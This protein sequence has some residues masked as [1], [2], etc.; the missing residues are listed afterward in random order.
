MSAKRAV[1]SGLEFLN[2]GGPMGE[3]IRRHDWSA[4]ALGAIESWP[5]HLKTATAV[6]L[7]SKVPIVMLWGETGVMIYNDGYSVFAGAR[8]PQLLGSDVREGWPEVADFNDHVMKTGLAGG[9]LSY[10]DQELTLNRHGRAEQVWM[11]LDYSPLLDEG[12]EPAGVMAIVVETTSKVQAERR[13]GGE[14]QR[15]AQLFEQAPSF[16]AMVH[17]PSFRFEMANPSYV[18]LIGHRDLIGRTVAEVLPEVARQGYLELL[19]KVYRSGEVYLAQAAPYAMQVEPGGAVTQRY[20]DFVYQPIRDDSG[21]VTDIFVEGTDVTSRVEDERR[22][23]AL[24]RLTELLREPQDPDGVAFVAARLLGQTLAVSRVGYGTIDLGAETLHIKR[25]WHAPGV[26]TLSGTTRLRDY[27][28]FID[29]LKNNEFISIADVRDDPRTATA[30]GAL[31]GRSA[32]AFVNVPVLEQGLLVAVMFINHWQRRDWSTAELDFVREVAN[33]TRMAVERVKG[34][35]ARAAAARAEEAAVLA[36]HA[37]DRQFRALVTASSDVIY[38]M[39]PAWQQ[40]RSLY[41]GDFLESATPERASWLESYV[42]EEDQPGVAEAIARAIRTR[43]IFQLEHRVRRADGSIGWTFSRAIPIL[44]ESSGEITEW[45]GAATDV[46]HRKLVELELQDRDERLRE[47]DR[48]KDEFLA[49]LAHEL[50]NPLA[51]IRNAVYLL[52]TIGTDEQRLHRLREMLERQVSHMVRLVDDLMEI[53][54]VSRG[55]IELR[56][57]RVRIA[58]VI[59]AAVESVRPLVDASRHRLSISVPI[60]ALWVQGDAVRLTQVVANLLNNAARY[61]PAGGHIE[62]QAGE[63]PGEGDGDSDRKDEGEGE[64]QA[65]RIVISVKDNGIGI[66]ADQLPRLFEMFSQIERRISRAHGGLG[67]GLS[68]AQRLVQMHGGTIRAA[69]AGPDQGSCFS[70]LLPAAA[71]PM[72]QPA[73][74]APSPPAADAADAVRPARRVLLVDDNRDAADSTAE[75]LKELGADLRVVYDGEAALMT[76][77]DWQPALVILDIGMPGM[78]GHEVARRLRAELGERTP[79]L[80]ALTGWGQA[81]DRAKTQASGFDHHLVKPVDLQ[82]LQRLMAA[83]SA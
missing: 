31:E 49:T 80:S 33:R 43:D 73:G 38:R 27:G 51:P 1:A 82:D 79:V 8:H 57:D 71:A 56:Q 30:A 60:R 5:A 9:T 14:R 61:T 76:V 12:G 74:A 67:I 50:R 25:D 10:Q 64:A 42:P 4:S 37:Q 75:L 78:D 62:L 48:R 70:V 39:D 11:N 13:L 40:V 32:R 68:L 66:A 15:L 77:N 63:E 20:L 6:M 55:Q 3:A 24:A 2:G 65:N 83:I 21:R 7:R 29:S 52:S 16:M 69:S 54:R 53:S 44:S 58:D 46:T 47:A 17:G 35:S 23:E 41:G 72:P 28:S 45:F 59:D 34:E 19:D 22:R 26:E 36:L 18:R 81:D